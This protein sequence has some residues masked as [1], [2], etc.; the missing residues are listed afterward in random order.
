MKNCA[1]V[2]RYYVR[3]D[4]KRAGML[5]KEGGNLIRYNSNLEFKMLIAL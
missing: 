1:H 3:T 5:G 4:S 2:S